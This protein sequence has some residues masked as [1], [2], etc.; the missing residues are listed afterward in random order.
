[1]KIA[2]LITRS[3]NVGGAQVHVR[4]LS[5]AM[6][7]EGHEVW[8]LSGGAGPFTESLAG[9]GTPVVSLRHLMAPIEPWR[10]L[11][12]VAE[13]RAALR[14]LQPDLV[15]AHSS[16]AG[17][18]GRLAARSL[19]LPTVFTAHGWSF[20]PGVPRASAALYRWSERLAAPLASRII[21]VSNF[22]RELA[23]RER[24]SSAHRLVTI[25]NGMPDV[26]ETLR[27]DAGTAPVRLAM[28]ARF[29]PQK[30][31]AT[32]FRALAELKSLEWDLDLI[33]DGPLLPQARRLCASLGLEARVNFCGPVDTVPVLLSRAQIYLLI[34][35]WE[36]FPRSILEAMRAGL[37]VVASRV[38]GVAEAVEEGVS[39]FLAARGDSAAVAR[40]LRTLLQDAELR[41]RQGARGRARF[42][43]HFNLAQTVAKTVEVYRVVTGDRSPPAAASYAGR[44]APQG[45]TD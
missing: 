41:R 6:R 35:N 12:A 28:I 38:G 8:V 16:K 40:A 15:S 34:S 27:A 42:E 17:V 25:H 44:G 13:V 24:V 10:D 18:L 30:D 4:D 37:P 21:T 14:T 39:G 32:L 29:E 23:I 43:T 31:H 26:P 19:G 33:G 7:R 3:D 20:T 36:G 5:L 1:V 45:C 9:Q 11:R 2:Y 22:D